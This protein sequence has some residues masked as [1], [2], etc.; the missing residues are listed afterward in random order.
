[1]LILQEP[2]SFNQWA[3]GKKLEKNY[4]TVL[5]GVNDIS[6]AF[7]KKQHYA[8]IFIHLVK[9]FDTVDRIIV[10]DIGLSFLRTGPS[11]SS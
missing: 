4:S 2:F 11:V 5:K 6:F 1:M 9:D 3:A 10:K 8:S 7:D